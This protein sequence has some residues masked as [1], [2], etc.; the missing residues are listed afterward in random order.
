[1]STIRLPAPLRFTIAGEKTVPISAA[2]LAD[3]VPAITTAYPGLAER[4]LRDGAFGSFVTVFIDGE[5]VRFL[6]PGTPIAAGAVV[7]ILPAMSGGR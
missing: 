1:M 7:E 2:T 6:E 3:L 5:D 4:V